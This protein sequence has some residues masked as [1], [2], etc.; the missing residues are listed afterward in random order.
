MISYGKQHIDK[1]DIEAVINI[2]KGDWL[3]QGP[4]IESF[5]KSCLII[6]NQI[7]VRLLVMEQQRYI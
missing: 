1:D 5:E 2:L 3:T 4:A 7:I 6:S